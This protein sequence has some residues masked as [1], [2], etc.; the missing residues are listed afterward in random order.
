VSLA[1]AESLTGADLAPLRAVLMGRQ[2]TLRL[3]VL[4]TFPGSEGV[5]FLGVAVTAELLAFHAD[6]HFALAD[7]I[8][9]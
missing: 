1:V 7:Q 2:P 6:V 4:G 8:I 3:Y 9:A 5:L